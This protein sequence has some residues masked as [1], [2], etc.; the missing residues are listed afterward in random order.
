MQTQKVVDHIVHWLKDYAEKH[1]MS[2]W[3]KSFKYT[4]WKEAKFNKDRVD[5]MRKNTKKNLAA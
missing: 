2:N 1:N 3:K 5:V 4:Q